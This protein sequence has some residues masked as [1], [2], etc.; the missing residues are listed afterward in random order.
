MG[1]KKV[2]FR[3]QVSASC[4]FGVRHPNHLTDEARVVDATSHVSNFETL[5]TFQFL[6]VVKVSSEDISYQ[7]WVA[8]H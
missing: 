4:F 8:S 6:N 2:H 1:L 7:D 5:R 3:C